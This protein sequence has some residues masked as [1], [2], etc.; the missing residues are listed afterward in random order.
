M[1]TLGSQYCRQTFKQGGVCIYVLNNIQF[2]PIN[3][4]KFNK[5][6]DLESCVLKLCLTTDSIILICI[7]RSPIGNFKFFLKQLESILNKICKLSTDI[8]LCGDFNINHLNDTP[9]KQ[10]L[11]SLLASYNLFSTAN[12]P[13]RICNNFSTLID[14]IYISTKICNFS[15]IP[16]INGLSDHD[17]QIITLSHITNITPNKVSFLSRK[18]N[19]DSILKFLNLLSYENWEE[20][21]VDKDVNTL[22][23]NFLNTY[24]KIFNACFPIKKKQHHKTFK[25]WLTIGIRTSCMNKRKLYKTYRISKNLNFIKYNKNYCKIL[26]SVII[27]AKKKHFDRLLMKSTNKTNTTW[28]IV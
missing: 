22:F 20:I 8:I 21:F 3:L 6:K 1:Y 11:E 28:N 16:L 23:N 18:I 13:T 17:G 26:S 19:K 9:S 12:F 5:E 14:N 24:L 10:L 4:D 25:P 7:Y 2:S 27:S 15:I